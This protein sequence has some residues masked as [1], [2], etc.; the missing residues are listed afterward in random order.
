M[1]VEALIIA[2]G[3]G[4]RMKG[5]GFPKPLVPI[6]GKPLLELVL[7]GAREAGIV[8]FTIVVGFEADRIV[9]EVGSGKKLGV[10][11]KYV[12]NPRWR[13]G[14]GRSVAA[15]RNHLRGRFLLLM[16]DHLFDPETLARL[17][18]LEIRTG[19]SAL[20]VDRKLGGTH[21]D[22]ADATKVWV[23]D[24]LVKR[25][26]KALSPF[27]ALDTGLFSY[28]PRIFEALE[29]SITRG[30][31]SLTAANRILAGASLLRAHDIEDRLWIDVDDPE[32]LRRAEDD[33]PGLLEPRPPAR[34]RRKK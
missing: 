9:Q 20:C 25:I 21:Y 8:N 13:L 15:A 1:T 30:A 7:G 19:D 23:E 10:R 31:D 32:M 6:R 14:N 5:S 26:G 18:S 33:F 24:G 22:P 3:E 28:S 29:E 12:H 16:G 17:T 34:Q 2:A 4:R 11:I 27:N